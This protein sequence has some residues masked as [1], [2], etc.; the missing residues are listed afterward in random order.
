ME[1]LIEI[2]FNVYDSY[3][4]KEN[5]ILSYNIGKYS[6]EFKF[7]DKV[8][9]KNI[10]DTIKEKLESCKSWDD[11]SYE[12][13]DKIIKPEYNYK[14]LIVSFLN[15]PFDIKLSVNSFT[16]IEDL[17]NVIIE[18]NIIRYKRKNHTFVLIET[19]DNFKKYNYNVLLEVNLVSTKN[20]SYIAESS[21]L[22]ILDINKMIEKND[23]NTIMIDK[24][25]E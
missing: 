9:S 1:K 25:I 15:L 22:K 7:D 12:T 13:G 16:E 6:D 17:D 8:I 24:I 2:I 23:Y 3:K 11:I 21:I 10:Y 4:N 18:Q 5:T 20:I 19:K 14:N